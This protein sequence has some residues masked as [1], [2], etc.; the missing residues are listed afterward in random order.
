MPVGRFAPSPTGPLH[1]G[2]LRTAALAWCAARSSGGG[3]LVRMEDLTTGA[4]AEQEDAQ[5]ADLA[6]LGL[7]HDGPVVRQSDRTDRYDL[8]ITTLSRLGLTYECFCSRREVREAA[9]APHGDPSGPEGAYPGTCRN[10]TPAERD[11]RRARGRVPAL[12]LRAGS[13]RVV[14]ADRRCGELDVTVDDVVIRRAD[15][16]AAYHL[17]VVVD[18]ASQGVTQV[19]RGDDLWPST[20][21]H[22]LL[23]E[24][25]G[26]PTP[27]YLHV[28]LVLGPDG[29][30]L[31]KRHGAVTLADRAEA[32]ESPERVLGALAATLGWAVPGESLD[33]GGLLDRYDP[34]RLPAEPSVW[35]P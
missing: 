10:L 11:D 31:A 7:H 35:R 9:V 15:G 24:L 13:R 26:L 21:V 29:A 27:G 2:N 4:A 5:L 22:V 1:L 34:D 16:V 17:A 23:Q 3:F 12:R 25:L 6:A 19:V 18:D 33:A 28:P 30:R 8:A 14:V 20:P 32:G